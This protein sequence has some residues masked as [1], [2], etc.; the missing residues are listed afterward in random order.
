MA[1]PTCFSN[2]ALDL[3]ERLLVADP[4]RR[5]RLA[6]VAAHP[7]VRGR[8]VLVPPARGSPTQ[9]RIRNRVHVQKFIRRIFGGKHEGSSLD[10]LANNQWH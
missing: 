1:A 7:Y 3:V 5:L 9:D 4:A 8:K 6:D 10:L 2:A